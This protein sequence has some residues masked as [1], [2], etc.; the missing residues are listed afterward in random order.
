MN[1]F[2][3]MLKKNI[4]FSCLTL[5]KLI[6]QIN[7]VESNFMLQKFPINIRKLEIATQELR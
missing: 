2:F 1:K 4:S 6:P 7:Q 3:D 5:Q